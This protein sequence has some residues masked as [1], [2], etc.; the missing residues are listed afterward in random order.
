MVII[1]VLSYC[2]LL[3]IHEHIVVCY[4][5][6]LAREVG[7]DDELN[8][9]TFNIYVFLCFICFRNPPWPISVVPWGRTKKPQTPTTRCCMACL[10]FHW[11][12]P[13]LDLCCEVHHCHISVLLLWPQV[14]SN[15][16]MPQHS[17]NSLWT[18]QNFSL[19]YT[20][21]QTATSSSIWRAC[22]TGDCS[23]DRGGHTRAD[24]P[25][26]THFVYQPRNSWSK[27]K[28][29]QKQQKKKLL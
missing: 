5:F 6:E 19:P 4:Q 2:W 8:T 15:T 26:F 11:L 27:C 22:H 29:M 9:C 13:G 3:C 12:T 25:N 20:L 17:P 16:Q 14:M 10:S 28:N 1:I 18:V 21:S 23:Y 7:K 24:L